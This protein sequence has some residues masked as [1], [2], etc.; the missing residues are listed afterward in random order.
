MCRQT[1]VFV[2]NVLYYLEHLEFDV[3]H[4]LDA[5]HA[6]NHGQLS[7]E[8]YRA[9]QLIIFRRAREMLFI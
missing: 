3:L 7:A 6:F 2:M 4:S 1:R 9:H 8:W 5:I